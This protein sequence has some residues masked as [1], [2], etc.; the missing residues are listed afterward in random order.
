MLR[1][2]KMLNNISRSQATYRGQRVSREGL[3]PPHHSF[4]LAICKTPGSSQEQ[5][6]RELCLNKSTVTRTLAHLEEQGY[7]KRE[8]S[9]EDKRQLAVFPT[10]RLLDA[11]PEIRDVSREWHERISEGIPEEELAV[12]HSVLSKMEK[13]AKEIIDG[14]DA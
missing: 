6:A 3:C 1:F 11:L 13:R 9:P 10:E 5:L 14:E 7:I 2:M 8:Q 4:V 12:F